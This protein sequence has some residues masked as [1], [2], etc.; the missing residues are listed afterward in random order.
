MNKL[1]KLRHTLH[2]NPELSGNE[3]E[4]AGRITD[5]L[6]RYKPDDI[7]DNLG[8]AG[9]MA[10]FKGA[11]STA[12]KHLLFRAELDAIA[13]EEETGASYASKNS[14]VMHACGHDGHMTIISGLAGQIS[15]NR[16]E[17]VNIYLL[18]QPA[19]ETGQGASAVM[20]DERFSSINFDH[21]FALHNLPGF[22]EN[23]IYV[24]SGA[25]ASASAGVEISLKGAYSHA[26]YPEQGVNPAETVAALIQKI[27]Q[28]LKPFKEAANLNKAV[29]TFIK[30][31]EPAFGISPG[32][33]RLGYTIRSATDDSLQ[34]GIETI[35]QVFE[36]GKKRFRGDAVLRIVEPFKATVNSKN[37][38][39][40]L[41]K[42]AQRCNVPVTDLDDAFPW[43]EDFGEFRNVCP[44]TIFGLGAG[45]H[46]PPLH[47]ER[48]DFNDSLIETGIQLFSALIKEYSS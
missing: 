16:P 15:K 11:G 10:V 14:G 39:D 23:K 25:F 17:N 3:Y 31:G 5:E 12:D 36:K 18:F 41:K 29:C 47:S 42:A 7:V 32:S 38:V 4:T 2:A 43:S 27:E 8:G 9:V 35:K 13:V 44:I 28:K 46:H 22:D 19:E 6:A 34:E 1:L 48:Y 37:G 26:A 24:K 20:G 21:A 33:A 45:I 40:I 30:M